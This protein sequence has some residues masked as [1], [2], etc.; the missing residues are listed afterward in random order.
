MQEF[1][2]CLRLIPGMSSSTSKGSQSQP[3]EFS[4]ESCPAI[5]G[6]PSVL[7]DLGAGGG[8]KTFGMW[9]RCFS[10]KNP[11]SWSD[12]GQFQTGAKRSQL[13]E[14]NGNSQREWNFVERWSCLF[15][16]WE[17]WCVW[18]IGNFSGVGGTTPRIPSD[19]FPWKTPCV[20]GSLRDVV[21]DLGNVGKGI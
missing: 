2:P 5:L 10:R 17:E 21:M 11:W 4:R 6:F 1:F 13:P 14:N 19:S 16:A 3:A 7:L 9:Q 12:P 15:P 18:N 20:A 8:G